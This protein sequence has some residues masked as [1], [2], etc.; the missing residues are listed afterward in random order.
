MSLIMKYHTLRDMAII[1]AAMAGIVLGFFV[2]G[3][4]SGTNAAFTYLNANN[5]TLER[6]VENKLP[7]AW[8]EQ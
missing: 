3:L 6:A 5:E 4:K 8:R 2:E 7:A 1:A